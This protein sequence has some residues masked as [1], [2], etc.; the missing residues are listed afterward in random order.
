MVQTS[1]G[2][3]YLTG[4]TLLSIVVSRGG[5]DLK[6][7]E[8]LLQY[9]ANKK[10]RLSYGGRRVEDLAAGDYAMIDVLNTVPL[11]EWPAILP[12]QSQRKAFTSCYRRRGKYTECMVGF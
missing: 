10:I 2:G 12:F 6:I 9:V 5:E 7:A 11:L 4:D 1:T 8:L 3:L